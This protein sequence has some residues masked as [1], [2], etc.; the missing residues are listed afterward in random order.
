[1]QGANA[2]AIKTFGGASNDA[3]FDYSGQYLAVAGPLQ[4]L[5]HRKVIYFIN[6]ALFYGK[7]CFDYSGQYLAVA[8]PLQRL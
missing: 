6:H 1:M 7:S 4:R 2:T 5:W 8:G 3:C